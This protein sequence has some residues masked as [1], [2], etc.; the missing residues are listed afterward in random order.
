MSKS[1]SSNT[2]DINY[3][4]EYR[5]P[6]CSKI[7]FIDIFN[8]ENKLFMSTKCTN[9]HNYSKP[10]EEMQKMSKTSL[11][12]QYTCEYCE[13]ENKEN[14]KKLSNIFYYCSNCYK[15]FCLAHGESHILKDNHKIFLN[16]NFDSICM[17]HGNTIIGYCENHNKN[18]CVRCNHFNENNRKF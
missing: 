16:K 9:N 3:D 12:S 11:I 6:D 4:K 18:Y 14:N 5:C 8:E 17:E 15:F 10:F 1:I 7:P 13:N 2:L